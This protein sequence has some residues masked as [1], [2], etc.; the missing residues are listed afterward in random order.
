MATSAPVRIGA[1]LGLIST[2]STER[3]LSTVAHPST[4]ASLPVAATSVMRTETHAVSS[5]PDSTATSSATAAASDSGTNSDGDDDGNDDGNSATDT[6]AWPSSPTDNGAGT[7]GSST[8]TVRGLE[9]A[10]AVVGALFVLSL[11]VALWLAFR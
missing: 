1:A 5:A 3:P 4:G 8:G 9:I 10:V 11:G 7:A 6:D 2:P